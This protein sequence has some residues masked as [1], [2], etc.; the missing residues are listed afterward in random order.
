VIGAHF[1][2]K[3]LPPLDVVACQIQPPRPFAY[4]DRRV[5]ARLERKRNSGMV[6]GQ[7]PHGS[8]PFDRRQAA[9]LE[10]AALVSRWSP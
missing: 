10:G 4:D 6:A 5:E 7:G 9:A 3:T 8:R 1:K 2:L